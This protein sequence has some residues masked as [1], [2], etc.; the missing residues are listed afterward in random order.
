VNAA[1]GDSAEHPTHSVNVYIHTMV[2]PMAGIPPV[3]AVNVAST[4]SSVPDATTAAPSVGLPTSPW[5]G[6]A[7]PVVP[8]STQV[9]NTSLTTIALK[10]LPPL[11]LLLPQL[12][13]LQ[14][15]LYYYIVH[16]K[17]LSGVIVCVITGVR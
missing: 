16:H 13:Q 2:S 12:V 9:E 15:Q 5:R 1:V 8:Q 10:Q 4:G 11:L 6:G 14:L 7:V 3:S 17:C